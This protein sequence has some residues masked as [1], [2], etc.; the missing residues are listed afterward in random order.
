MYKR[1]AQGPDIFFYH[2][3]LKKREPYPLNRIGHALHNHHICDILVR[4]NKFSK[5]YPTLDNYCL[6]YT[7][8]NPAAISPAAPAPIIIVLLFISA[9]VFVLGE[10]RTSK[11]F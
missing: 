11:P 2:G 4:M 1:Q 5:Q 8:A 6:L 10:G 9:S 3:V 7:S